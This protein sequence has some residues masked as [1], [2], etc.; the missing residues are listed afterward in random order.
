[1]PI[2]DDVPTDAIPKVD[3]AGCDNAQAAGSMF[4]EDEEEEE[5][6]PL[7]RKN[8]CHYRGSDGGSNIPSQALSALIN[9]KGLLISNL[10]QAMEEI[11]PEDILSKPPE[12]DIP[13]I[14]SEV[15]D[16][17]LS[18]LDSI[19]QEVTRV[20][21]R[22]SS[23]LEGSLPCKYI[24]SSHPTPMEVAKGPSAL[25]VPAIEDQAPEG[26]AGSYLAPEG[27]A[28]SNPAPVGSASSNLAADGVQACSL[29]TASMKSTSDHPQSGPRR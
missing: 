24:D 7:I 1:M 28:G 13:T 8:S 9:L 22:A 25:E 29:S 2:P 4:D 27:V 23:T 21:S 5:E 20:V 17:G 11:I 16:S 19:E 26:G 12:A 15:P 10:D 3:A 18:L 6:I 14:C